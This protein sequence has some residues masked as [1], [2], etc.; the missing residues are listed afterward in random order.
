MPNP[1]VRFEHVS[2]SVAFY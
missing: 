2:H 1:P